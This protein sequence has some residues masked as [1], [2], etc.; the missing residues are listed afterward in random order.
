MD[1]S[2]FDPEVAAFI[3][4]TQAFGVASRSVAKSRAAYDRM[5]RAFSFPRPAGLG[6]QDGAFGTLPWRRYT[7]A[8]APPGV[9]VLY[10]HGGGFVLGGLDSHD[11]ICA[12]LADLSGTTLLA[13]DY[14]RAPEHRYPAALDD[15]Q[16]AYQALLAQG[17]Q[18]VVAGDSAG[19]TLAVALCLRLRRLGLEMPAGQV[20]IYAGLHPDA[21]RAAGTWREAPPMLSVH[22]LVQYR[23]YYTGRPGTEI[24]TDPEQAPLATADFAGLP[25]ACVF[26]ADIDPLALDSADYQAALRVCDVAASLHRGRFLPHGFLRGRRESAAIAEVFDAIADA[27]HRLARGATGAEQP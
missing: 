11:S 4:R 27:L 7:P 14:R 3:A 18:V 10:M 9:T 16:A 6:V 5:C 26:A 25:E 15:A 13:I 23:Q 8:D 17:Q 22:D 24:A 19:G 2:G 20:P 21:R 12:D 1:W